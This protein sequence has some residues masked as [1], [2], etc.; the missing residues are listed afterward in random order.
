MAHSHPKLA[1][2]IADLRLCFGIRAMEIFLKVNDT[3]LVAIVYR[4]D[5]SSGIRS[6]HPDRAVRTILISQ[7]SDRACTY[8]CVGPSHPPITHGK[9]E[10]KI[11]FPFR[12]MKYTDLEQN[13]RASICL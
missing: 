8:E 3:E 10:K 9:R 13:V 5:G 2:D 1:G 4:C 12:K 6:P 7:R 11:F